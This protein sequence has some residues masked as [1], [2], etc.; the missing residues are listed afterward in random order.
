MFLYPIYYYCIIDQNDKSWL[1]MK[2]WTII[3]DNIMNYVGEIGIG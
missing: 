3:E 1:G 2:H